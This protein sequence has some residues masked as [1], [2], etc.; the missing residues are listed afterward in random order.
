MIPP[1][2]KGQMQ[3]GLR[4]GNRQDVKDNKDGTRLVPFSTI[5][6]DFSVQYRTRLNQRQQRCKGL[7][8]IFGY[9]LLAPH[10]SIHK[11]DCLASKYHKVTD[12]VGL[13]RQK[14]TIVRCNHTT[15]VSNDSIKTSNVLHIAAESAGSR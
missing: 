11:D 14:V 4:G 9:R 12:T 2:L 15:A 6:D 5:H 7:G 8:G 1:L 3:N 13:F 10:G